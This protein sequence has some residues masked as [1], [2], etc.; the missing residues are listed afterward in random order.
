MSLIFL[1][2]FALQTSTS[3]I[4]FPGSCPEVPPTIF[5]SDFLL[6]E[7]LAVSIVPFTADS[8]SFIFANISSFPK[9]S[10]L[11]DFDPVTDR[12]NLKFSFRY[13]IDSKRA[14]VISP[15]KYN[16][17]LLSSKRNPKTNVT[18][19]QLKTVGKFVPEQLWSRITLVKPSGNNTFQLKCPRGG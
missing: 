8:P 12:W 4:R 9:I 5:S 16:T 18:E 17:A 3:G 6:V 1:F 7:Y 13:D 2:L 10:F 19:T 14:F 11:L 15:N